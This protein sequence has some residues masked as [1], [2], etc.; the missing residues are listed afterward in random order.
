MTPL[1]EARLCFRCD[2]PHWIKQ[3]LQRH[4][5][6]LSACLTLCF[7]G[8]ATFAKADTSFN[9]QFAKDAPQTYFIVSGPEAARLARAQVSEI[10]ANKDYKWDAKKGDKIHVLTL[11]EAEKEATSTHFGPN[12]RIFLIARNELHGP[13]S[14]ALQSVMPA[15]LTKLGP[16]SSIARMKCLNPNSGKLC[17]AMAFVAPD[18]ERLG[19]I[20][21][22]VFD[23]SYADFRNMT[24]PMEKQYLTHKVAVFSAEA[25]RD[26]LQQW[27][28]HP[29]GRVA[30]GRGAED[31]G[32]VWEDIAW[33]PIAE[34]AQMTPE[35]L[36]E[37]HVVFFLD[38]S[39]QEAP[40]EAASKLLGDLAVNPTTSLIQCKAQD[41]GLCVAV[42][43]APNS[44]ILRRKAVR[45]ANFEALRNT[46]IADE[47]TDLRHIAKTTLLVHGGG[48]RL[49]PEQ[50]EGIRF[51]IAKEMRGNLHMEVEERGPIMEKLQQEVLLQDLQGA[52]DTAKKLRRTSGLR[53][54]WLLQPLEFGGS[55]R[56]EAHETKLTADPSPFTESEP[57]KPSDRVSTGLFKDR[58]RTPEE[59]AKANEEWRGQYNE[60]DRKRIAHE[61]LMANGA[62]QWERT[63]T[64]TCSAGSRVMLRLIDLDNNGKIVWEREAQSATSDH[65]AHRAERVTMRG[66]QTPPP[67]LETPPSQDDCPSVLKEN[68]AKAAGKIGLAFL[69]ETA[70]LPEAGA[71]PPVPIIP[72]PP[73]IPNTPPS[74]DAPHVASVEGQRITISIGSAEGVKV[75]DKI[76][77]KLKVR[78]VKD[79][80][81]GKILET[82]VTDVLA[83]RVT[84]VGVAADCA[85]ATPQDAA[86]LSSLKEGMPIV[87]QRVVAP[88]SIPK[89]V[90]PPQKGRKKL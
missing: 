34:Y 41:N 27:G 89:P 52:T 23:R 87:W 63:V 82:I 75:G 11:E 17:F 86:K 31:A 68:A 38:R 45:Y 56:Y 13:L 60:W 57:S 33:H 73:P 85:P 18:G 71:A 16:R 62:C 6:H 59:M 51:E 77:V 28:H 25:N 2:R 88:K 40:P 26:L 20:T 74:M 15:D 46:P 19:R 67:S 54:V 12:T 24:P 35:Q 10:L 49:S 5:S 48:V 3:M 22:G 50:A 32:G 58:K 83:M 55:T 37:W 14:E 84:R 70:W 53:Y 61:A 76:F 21:Q 4:L 30:V 42:F 43:T 44:V 66:Y 47:A 1:L 8:A 78:E 90:T 79:N 36:A 72:A 80:T 81:T 69:A 29:G 64:R 9:R 7:I 39:H 65:S